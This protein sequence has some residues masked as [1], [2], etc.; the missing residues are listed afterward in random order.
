MKTL[1]IMRHA[2]AD[3]SDPNVDDHQRIISK[4]GEND[5]LMVYNW[6]KEVEIEIQKLISSSA[7]R[8]KLTADRVFIDKKK[9][10][11]IEPRLY[12]CSKLEM[13]N[14]LKE[15]ENKIDNLAVVGH[16]PSI[17]DTIK[18]LVGATRPDL[19]NIMLR[20]YPPAGLSIIV[21]NVTSWQEILPKDG[22]LDAFVSPDI[23]EQEKQTG[24]LF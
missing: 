14:I 12:L 2:E 22:V 21:F 5:C 11:Y 16:E 6:L 17:S 15:T 24:N 18:E 3:E 13:I 10:I 1:I 19:T 20:K 4:K 23:L 8:A 7:L 9:S